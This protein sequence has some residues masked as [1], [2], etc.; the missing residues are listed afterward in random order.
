MRNTPA[1]PQDGPSPNS[2]M[3]LLLS[4]TFQNPQNQRGTAKHPCAGYRMIWNCEEASYTLSSVTTHTNHGCLEK[5]L[6]LKSCPSTCP[7][8]VETR[9]L[10]KPWIV[11]AVT[12]TG[13]SHTCYQFQWEALAKLH[14]TFGLCDHTP[15]SCQMLSDFRTLYIDRYRYMYVRIHRFWC[16][17]KILPSFFCKLPLDA[18]NL[19]KLCWKKQFHLLK[20]LH[21]TGVYIWR[22]KK[23]P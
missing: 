8:V 7:S 5:Q 18:C 16:G 12:I 22:G 2:S 19:Y 13:N 4:Y 6:R 17:T 11:Q 3:S 1:Q 14:K 10:P 9:F 23:P 20:M 21:P 15:L